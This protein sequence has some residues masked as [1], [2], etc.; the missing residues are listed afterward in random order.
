MKLLNMFCTSPYE[1]SGITEHFNVIIY[2]DSMYDYLL[3]E[4][5]GSVYSFMEAQSYFRLEEQPYKTYEEIK[6]G[7]YGIS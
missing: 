2:G 3:W 4:A 5:D 1:N 6:A 7:F